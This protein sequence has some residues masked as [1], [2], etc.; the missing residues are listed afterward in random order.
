MTRSWSLFSTSSIFSTIMSTQSERLKFKR[1]ATDLASL[2]FL[3]VLVDRLEVLGESDHGEVVGELVLFL[4][5][6]IIELPVFQIR[7][8]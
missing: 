2:T 7:L 5:H 8:W 1:K 3:P 4:R 6:Y